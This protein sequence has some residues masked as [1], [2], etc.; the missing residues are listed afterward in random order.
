MWCS[1]TD[2]EL[3]LV[4]LYWMAVDCL[5][6]K[7]VEIICFRESE[8]TFTNLSCQD[9]S[10]ILWAGSLESSSVFVDFYNMNVIDAFRKE[11]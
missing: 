4:C 1:P 7:L 9:N 5:A 11:W 10:F 6:S 8:L 3:S 2:S